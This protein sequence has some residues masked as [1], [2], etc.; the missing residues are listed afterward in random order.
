VARKIVPVST[1]ETFEFAVTLIRR[2]LTDAP[3]KATAASVRF[4]L[5]GNDAGGPFPATYDADIAGWVALCPPR[6]EPAGTDLTY[7]RS[8]PV[9]GIP[10]ESRGTLRVTE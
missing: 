9:G 8:V 2:G 4:L 3:R 6:A 5:N 10:Y 1:G 7:I